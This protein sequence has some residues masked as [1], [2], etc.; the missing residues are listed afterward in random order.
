MTSAISASHFTDS[1]NTFPTPYA[2]GAT[3]LM[4]TNGTAD[5]YGCGPGFISCPYS[6]K[7]EG[8]LIYNS[9]GENSSENTLNAQICAYRVYDD[10]LPS[11]PVNQ[12]LVLT[13]MVGNAR[14]GSTG[15]NMWVGAVGYYA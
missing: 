5:M 14:T 3:V 4:N 6:T 8:G 13:Y 11:A 1:T 2:T 7:S 9:L 12:P 10:V 15:T